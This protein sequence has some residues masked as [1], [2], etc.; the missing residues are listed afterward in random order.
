MTSSPHPHAR[1]H[2]AAVHSYYICT[3]CGFIYDGDFKTAP[4][5]Y[6]CPVCNVPKS[7]CVEQNCTAVRA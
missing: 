4:A 6:K 1:M 7:K 5:S 3:A 2:P